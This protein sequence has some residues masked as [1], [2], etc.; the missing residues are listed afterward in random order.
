MNSSGFRSFLGLVKFASGNERD[1]VPVAVVRSSVV[2]VWVSAG[3]HSDVR[4]L[5]CPLENPTVTTE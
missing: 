5:L 3:S 1:N 4:D 2:F